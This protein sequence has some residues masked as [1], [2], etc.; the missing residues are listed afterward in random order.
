MPTSIK[1]STFNGNTQTFRG[2][3][4]TKWQINWCGGE[5][6]V[7]QLRYLMPSKV[8]DGNK[9][10]F[11]SYLGKRTLSKPC[12]LVVSPQV[13]S[14]QRKNK[15]MSISSD[16]S[17]SN[18]EAPFS[19]QHL[20]ARAASAEGLK[21]GRKKPQA[22]LRQVNNSSFGRRS[23]HLSNTLVIDWQRRSIYMPLPAG[24]VTTKCP[25]LHLSQTVSIL[26][27]PSA[28]SHFSTRHPSETWNQVSYPKIL[29]L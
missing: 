26:L 18:T 19:C 14:P 23:D 7:I 9:V 5:E 15:H 24:F 21:C 11:F 28:S 1:T 25:D 2:S 20:W 13:R 17:C 27:Q 4:S 12:V 16:T 6:K 10:F 3:T 29:T 8:T 22:D